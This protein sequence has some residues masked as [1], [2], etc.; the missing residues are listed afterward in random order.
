M[1]RKILKYF[2]YVIFIPLWWLQ[3]LIPRNDKIWVFGAWYGQRYSDNSRYLFNYVNAEHAD[4]KAIWITRDKKVKE[5]VLNSGG[6][7]YLQNEIRGIFYCLMAKNIFVSSGKKDVNYLCLNGA[8]WIQ[9]WHG[10]PLKR[11]GL[12]DKFS[13]AN[14][15]FQLNIVRLLFPFAYE[16]NY[17]YTVS[18]APVF[19]KKMSQS[20]NIPVDRVLETGCPRNDIFYSTKQD[21]FNQKIRDEFVDC[22]LIYYLPTFRGFDGAKTILNS[23]D[24]DSDKLEVFLE[25]HNMVFISKGHYIDNSLSNNSSID[26]RVIHLE[27]DNVDEINA[28]LKDADLL[29]TDYSSAYFDFLLTQRP[30]IFAAFDLEQ[31]ISGSRELYFDYE[32]VI[33]GEIV[34]NWNGLYT[35]LE[36]IWQDAEHKAA[37]AEKNAV[38][39]LHHDAQ[40]SQRVFR[41][42]YDK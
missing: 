6:T 34:E 41:Y 29:I 28:M 22:K 32:A 25:H 9:L 42:F 12:D 31:Y 18:N 30:V 19:T 7:A 23:L 8:R 38:F 17:R 27:D 15:F 20:F 3:K 24:F 4:I 35:R 33:A 40:N 1:I 11:I 10:S 39:N 26:R 36:N 2:G 5:K 16:F 37:I 14:S 13:N 21:P